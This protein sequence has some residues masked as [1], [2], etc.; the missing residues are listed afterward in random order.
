MA[1][2]FISYSSKDRQQAEQLIELLASADSE[3]TSVDDDRVAH[4]F[5]HGLME[6]GERILSI[7]IL[8]LRLVLELC[9]TRRVF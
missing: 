3:S 9:P 5:I 6:K 8:L 2:I 4:E 7:R 1:D